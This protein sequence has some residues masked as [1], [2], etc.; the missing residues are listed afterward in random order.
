MKEIQLTKGYV[1]LVDD[2]D[3]EW[4]SKFKWRYNS[5]GYAA[6]HSPW[7]NGTRKTIYMHVLIGNGRPGFEVDHINHD[8]LDNRRSNLRVCTKKDNSHNRPIGRNNTSGY[9]GVFSNK[10]RKRWLVYIKNQY[11]GCF[12]DKI[13][14][15]KAYDAKAR[16]L[17][18]EFAC[19]NF[20]PD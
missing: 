3:Y 18:G 1:A 4:L 8:K 19:T 7:E 17:Y 12:D 20:E 6:R 16:E 5:A 9:K 14:A 11:V 13:E 2:S 15:A 10:N